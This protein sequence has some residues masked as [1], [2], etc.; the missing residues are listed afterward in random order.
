M[1]GISI[2]CRLGNQLFQYAFI[3]SLSKTLNSKYFISEKIERF[4]LPDYFELPHYNPNL[5]LLYKIIL[6][7]K[8]GYLRKPLQNYSLT[9]NNI[10]RDNEIY[11]G[12]FQSETFF[13]QLKNDIDSFIKVRKEYKQVFSNQY[14]NFFSEH[15][16]IAIHLR[17]GDYLNLDN[18]WLENLG[19]NNLTLPLDYYKN[20]FAAIE[21]LHHYKLMFISDD[22]E[23]VKSEFGYLENA[24]FHNNE[25]IIDFQIMMN[26]D[27]CIVSNSSF[28][29]WAAYLNPKATKKILCPKYWL[30]F[31]IKKEYPKNII[32]KDWKQIIA[33]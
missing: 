6:K 2:Q 16:T 14:G 10:A 4:T 5:N 33:K 27:I 9:R 31:N 21:N 26:A 11:V 8:K 28:A 32:P 29:W 7:I 30:G 1:I 12:Y 15:K 19:S 25:L 3:I 17:R 23:F 22:I 24:E 20:C 18:W 13:N